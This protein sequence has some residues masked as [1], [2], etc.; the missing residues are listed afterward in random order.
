MSAYLSKEEADIEDFIQGKDVH[1]QLADKLSI[2]RAQAKSLRHGLRYGMGLDTLKQ[3]LDVS[4]SRA[5]RIRDDY[6][7]KYPHTFDFSEL[8]KYEEARKT[9][10]IGRLIRFSQHKSH[11]KFNWLVQGSCVDLLLLALE[12]VLDSKKVELRAHIH[13]SLYLACLCNNSHPNCKQAQEVVQEL[14]ALY[15]F[16]WPNSAERVF[17]FGEI[18]WTT[19]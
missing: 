13:D 6:R 4:T 1:Q 11:S 18:E 5:E 17:K 3:T 14:E 7:A 15:P 16:F 2:T 8:L 12:H 19:S 9:P 10:L